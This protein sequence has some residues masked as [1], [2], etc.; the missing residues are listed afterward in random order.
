MNKGESEEFGSVES[1]H[2]LWIFFSNQVQIFEKARLSAMQEKSEI[3]SVIIPLLYAIK[4]SCDSLSLLA[5]RGKTRDSFVLA[6]T[7][8]ESIVNASFILAKGSE[9]VERAKQHALQKSYRDTNRELKIN[10]KK[11]NLK[12]GG[13]IDLSENAE[14]QAALARFTSKKG[15][16]I[17]SW[18]PETVKEQI[19]VI[20]KKYG[21]GVSTGLQFALMAVYR[22]ASDIG[23]GTFF[24]A[25][26]SLGLTSPSGAPKSPE[27]LAKHQRQNL[28]MLLM[29]IG[30]SLESLISI[31]AAELALPEIVAEAHKET[32]SLKKE[33]WTKDDRA[34]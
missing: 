7:I 1:T 22:H 3:W 27:E 4:D 6:R 5:Q 17:T 21:T 33:S 14:L 16:E 26:F 34:T 25:L 32:Q 29:M 30:L 28:S 20:D 11:L 12:W 9:A 2:R 13:T 8:Y 23:H 19:E 31:L 24:G 15:R 10:D 18:T